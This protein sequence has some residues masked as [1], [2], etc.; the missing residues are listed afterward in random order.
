MRFSPILLFHICAGTLGFL[1]GAVAVFFRKGSRW[2]A[3]AGNVFVISMLSLAASGVYMAIMKSQPGNILG[4]TLTF[5]LVATA[6]M[7]A[8]RRDGEA[9]LF[10]WGA[11][12][13]AS[14]LAAVE[15]IFGLEAATSPTGSKYG[16][17]PGPYFFLGSVAVIAATGDIRMLV[18][19][20]ISGT[21][22]IARH[23][24]RMCFAFFIAASSI[25]LARQHLFPAVLRKTGVLFLLSFFPLILMIFWLVRVRFTNAFKRTA[26]RYRTHEGLTAFR[27][28]VPHVSRFSKRGIPIPRAEVIVR[29]IEQSPRL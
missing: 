23:L 28:R 12:L 22:R 25:F 3:R 8:K 19:R 1:S 16:Y 15:L 17:G 7:A 5:Y 21:H 13:V 9:G 11:L 2:H 6:W 24:W 14:A 20:G 4:G 26:S 10:D 29:N 27:E 18:R